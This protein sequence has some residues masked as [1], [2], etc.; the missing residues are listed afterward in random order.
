MYSRLLGFSLI[1]I[2]LNIPVLADPVIIPPG[3]EVYLGEEGLDIR[4]AVPYPYTSIAYFPA[5]S[6]Q[7][8]TSHLI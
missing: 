5:G 1:L 4:Y 7:A 3:G 2:I 8:G 6:S